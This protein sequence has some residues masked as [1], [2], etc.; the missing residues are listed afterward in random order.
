MGLSFEEQETVISYNRNSDKM[1]VYTA[2][3]FL[4]ARLNKLKDIYKLVRVHKQDGEIVAAD[5]EAEK[6]FCTLRR[7]DMR[8]D[9]GEKPPII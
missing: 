6:R 3:S 7:K 8:K 9:G 5:Y 1:N 4:M 2:D